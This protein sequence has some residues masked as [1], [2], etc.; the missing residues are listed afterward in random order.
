ML[1]HRRDISQSGLG[2]ALRTTIAPLTV[3]TGV[4]VLLA[5]PASLCAQS[6]VGLL[7]DEPQEASS[8]TQRGAEA[9]ADAAGARDVSL[10]VDYAELVFNNRIVAP[11]TANL[12]F[13][14]D[15]VSPPACSDGRNNDDYRMLGRGVQDALVD[16]PDDP[17]CVSP[18]DASEDQAGMQ[19][20]RRVT[21]AG[22]LESDGHLT[23][24]AAGIDI[25]SIVAFGGERAADGDRIYRYDF[26]P[27]GDAT[28]IL[29]PFTR[30]IGLTLRLRIRVSGGGTGRFG[31]AGAACYVGS[32]AEPIRVQLG[33]V[34]AHSPAG[35]PS[36]RGH[37]Y[38]GESGRLELV[39]YN[40]RDSGAASG[41]GAFGSRDAVVSA[42]FGVPAAPGNVRMVL[43][44]RL[45]PPVAAP[46]GVDEMTIRSWPRPAVSNP[47][48]E[49]APREPR[50]PAAPARVEPAPQPAPSPPREVLRPAPPPT[51]PEPQAPAAPP[52]AAP[53]PQAPAAST[54]ATAPEPQAPAAPTPPPMAPLA[55]LEPIPVA[56]P[57]TEPPADQ[58]AAASA[59][60][61][62][63]P[64]GAL[65][66][67][68]LMPPTPP[69]KAGPSAASQAEGEAANAARALDDA[70][71]KTMAPQ[72]TEPA[73]IITTVPRVPSDATPAAPAAA[74][75]EPEALMPAPATQ[76]SS[77]PEPAMPAPAQLPSSEPD[78]AMPAPAQLPSSEPEAAMPAPAQQPSSEPEAAMPAPAQ[79]PSS[80]PD[81]VMPDAEA[82]P[83]VPAAALP[84]PKSP[85]PV[86]ASPES[87]TPS[88][89]DADIT[90]PLP[91][92]AEPTPPLEGPPA[93][94]SA[95]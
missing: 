88:A 57:E 74:P 16:F 75:S 50:A 3:A 82:L 12:A 60:D 83:S 28:G 31:G 79:L 67:D 25:P 70:H 24:P 55:P 91:R 32:I 6:E 4:C 84:D 66:D 41:C 36:L 33:T 51:A 1:E 23:F 76:P 62:A 78:A 40:V 95:P 38:D 35:L 53:E 47:P 90:T 14:W 94:P 8:A 48:S 87:A 56:V 52:P 46:E 58:P 43:R 80:E 39:G 44:G 20:S 86:D 68:E 10:S 19:E 22:R 65:R 15:A 85:P 72:L 42:A 11:A 61:A 45:D 18:A 64:F 21:F 93:P 71:L 89:K 54:P 17:Q 81:A 13:V 34:A 27:V 2:V 59:T 77:E 73:A 63:E 92:P 9:G 29:N 30:D 37:A 49:P 7:A 26:V 5:W 69:I